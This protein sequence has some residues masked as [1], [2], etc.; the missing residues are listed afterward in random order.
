LKSSIGDYQGA[1]ADFNAV[2]ANAPD[3]RRA[4][5]WRGG[6]VELNLND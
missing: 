3:D 6:T 2:I 4:F 1:I 5:F